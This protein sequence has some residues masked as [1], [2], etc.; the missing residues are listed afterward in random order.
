[1]E[2]NIMAISENLE[3]ELMEDNEMVKFDNLEQE[4]QETRSRYYFGEK[5]LI[6]YRNDNTLYW[7]KTD[8]DYWKPD[9]GELNVLVA[10]KARIDEKSD[11]T[12]LDFP[13]SDEV[14]IHNLEKEF[15]Q[16]SGLI[17][18][19]KET[20]YY[21][22]L[23]DCLPNKPIIID[24]QL[25]DAITD[26]IDPDYELPENMEGYVLN[27]DTFLRKNNETGKL[28]YLKFNDVT[29]NDFDNDRFGWIKAARAYFSYPSDEELL[30]E[31][32]GFRKESYG[33]AWIDEN[34]DVL[35]LGPIYDQR[36]EIL[37]NYFHD[38]MCSYLGIYS[39]WDQTQG[40]I[41]IE[42]GLNKNPFDYKVNYF[43]MLEKYMG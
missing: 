25:T 22:L 24:C 2:G 37:D 26:F 6:G 21:V 9:K 35:V 36:I 28:Y 41:D 32:R 29:K 20:N 33:D 11:T 40:W 17:T 12:I 4:P 16:S 5:M 31:L 1:M 8:K 38:R 13:T 7:L 15:L 42:S 27:E 19:Y 34:N 10:G 30:F 3:Q 18:Q 39:E 43:R 23:G 14:E